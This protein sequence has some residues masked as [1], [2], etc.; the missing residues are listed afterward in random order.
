MV[1]FTVSGLTSIIN[2]VLPEPHAGLLAGLLFGTKMT[3]SKALYGALVSSG[4]IHIIALSGMN[5]TI[6]EDL[7]GKLLLPW[8][9]RRLASVITLGVIC[10]FVWF[11]GPSSSIVRAAIMGSLTLIAVLFGRQYWALL[12]WGLAVSIM[13]LLHFSWLFEISFQ[14]SALATLGIILFGSKTA[15]RHAIKKDGGE[16][17]KYN[18]AS[19]CEREPSSQSEGLTPARETEDGSIFLLTTSAAS[20]VWNLVKDDFHLT[21]A[22]QVFTIPLILFHFHRVS[23]IA[24]LTNLAIGWAIVPLT[25]LGWMTVLVGFLVPP[26]SYIAGWIAWLFLEYIIRMVQVASFLPFASIQW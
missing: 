26:V 7:V 25:L 8:V 12:S 11:V 6:M 4:T 16:S 24:P 21:L 3:V 18:P 14:L 9:G 2:H 1:P 19:L 5:I 20:F 13:L 17:T 15:G 22:A 23:L 10:W